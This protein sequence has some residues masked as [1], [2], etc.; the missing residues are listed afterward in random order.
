MVNAIGRVPVPVARLADA[1]HV[2]EIFF[3]GLDS[4]LVDLLTLNTFVPDERHWHVGMPKKTNGGV[5]VSKTGGSVEIV[6]HVAPLFRRI[7]RRV[8]DREITDL[9]L[10]FQIAKPLDIFRGQMIA[11]PLN[12]RFRHFVEVAR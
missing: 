9:P 3:A 7:E 2:D 4:Q 10:Q 12:R 11:G 8:H 1:S 6:K 5:L